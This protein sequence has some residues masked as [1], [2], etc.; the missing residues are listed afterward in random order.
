MWLTVFDQFGTK[1]LEHWKNFRE[2]LETSL[3]P[4]YEVAK[5]WSKAPFVNPHLDPHNPN[6]WPDPWH[7]VLDLRLDDLAI[8]LG[9]LYTIKLTQRFTDTQC[10]IHMSMSRGKNPV[11][12]LIVDHTHVLNYEHGYV[13]PADQI[14]SIVTERIY[15]VAKLQ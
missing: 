14:K 15:S 11:Y 5:L 1:R 12:M 4:L 7:L 8:A 2:T 3:D 6:S 10:E 13:I 9:M